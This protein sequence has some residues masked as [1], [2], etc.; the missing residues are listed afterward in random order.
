MA[1]QPQELTVCVQPGVE[2]KVPKNNPVV[3]P[4]NDKK[5]FF[6]EPY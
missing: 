3:E 5:V 2:K 6:E 1:G 4:Q